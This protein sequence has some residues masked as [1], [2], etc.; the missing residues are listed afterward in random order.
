MSPSS[1]KVNN[2]LINELAQDGEETFF[3]QLNTRISSWLNNLPEENLQIAKILTKFV[4]SQP[5][6]KVKLNPDLSS[7]IAPLDSTQN[8]L[9][10]LHMWLLDL[11]LKKIKEKKPIE[12]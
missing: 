9:I 11:P 4:F 10:M 6:R 3:K 7:E 8:N 12:P 2:P 5:I 1:K